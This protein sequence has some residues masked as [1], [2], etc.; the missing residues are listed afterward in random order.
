MALDYTQ[1][2]AIAVTLGSIVGGVLGILKMYYMIQDRK[3]K[4][5]YE[6]FQEGGEWKI[7]IL[8]PDKLIHKFSITIDDNLIPLSKSNGRFYER[9]LKAGEGTTFDVPENITVDSKVIMKFDKNHKS[10]IY[11]DIPLYHS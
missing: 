10:I 7:L 9:T 1:L 11:K 2:A 5:S 6:K 3:P 4:F 8:H